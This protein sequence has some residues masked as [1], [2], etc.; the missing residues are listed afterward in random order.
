MNNIMREPKMTKIT[1]SIGATGAN[2][3]KA[4]ELLGIIT[5]M[6]AQII[7]SG[8]R[9]RIPAFGVKPKMELGTRITIRGDGAITLLRRLLGAV[10]NR[11]RKRQISENTFS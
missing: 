3:E 11:L 8:P 1:L 5:G 6:K 2:L 7:K 9:T 4:A 10:E